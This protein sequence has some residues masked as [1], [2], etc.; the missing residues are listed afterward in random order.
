MSTILIGSALLLY[1]ASTAVLAVSFAGGRDRPPQ[2]GTW[3]AA[4]G[5]ALHGS[6]LA[7][8]T[9][10]H[11]EL[12]LVG[13]AP[14]LATLGFLIGVFLLVTTAASES[15]PVGLVLLPLITVLATL[16]LLLGLR[17]TGTPLAFRGIWFAF[18]VLAALIGYAGL[19]MAFAA[20]LLYLLQFRELKSK[21]LG[22]IFRYF[23]S[24][25]TLD[26]LGR[27]A[28]AIGFPALTLALLLGWAWTIRFQ[29]SFV[30][31]NPQVIWGVC[32]WIAFLGV[33][34]ARAAGSAGRE[35]R[36]A[37]ASVVAFVGV[38]MLYVV[39]R[40]ALVAGPAFL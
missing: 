4:G 39:L 24:L 1:I 35:R 32:T 23:P 3:L 33:I 29:N 18:H 36:A 31:G 28:V 6:A 9:A 26:L 7:A 14:S 30:A 10:T 40:L 20:G 37:V 5:V 27:W 38:L 21:R 8:F 11:G 16:A 34:A 19:T 13:L 22:R 12:P 25:P 17:P 2:S 15:R